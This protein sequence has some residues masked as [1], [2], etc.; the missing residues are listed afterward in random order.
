M[1]L[2]RNAVTEA[3]PDLR[4][5]KHHFTIEG[6]SAATLEAMDAI[7]TAAG[8]DNDTCPLYDEE[9]S[10]GYWIDLSEI[11]CFKAAYKAA[12]AGV[13]EYMST[14]AEE[15]A[16]VITEAHA[17][18]I[19]FFG[20][21][22]YTARRAIINA[23]HVEALKLNSR[24]DA[25][26]D[27]RTDDEGN[28]P[29]EWCGNDIEAAHAEALA[30]EAER[31]PA[32]AEYVPAANIHDYPITTLHT[33]IDAE[34]GKPY[35]E[36]RVI[37]AYVARS[38]TRALESQQRHAEKYTAQD[39]RWLAEHNADHAFRNSVITGEEFTEIYHLI[40]AENARPLAILAAIRD[41]LLSGAPVMAAARAA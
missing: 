20:A 23:A 6:A 26:N 15:A 37:R 24:I 40:R 25:I 11:D 28:D 16:P 21:N 18:Q 8:W 3:N 17:E 1:K 36:K 27:P 39:V 29:R 32:A 4:G 5:R 22:D 41:A 9:I 12:K 35:A 14:S 2:V 38:I 10:C 31:A 34:D 33:A 7:L 13:K 19:I 30:M